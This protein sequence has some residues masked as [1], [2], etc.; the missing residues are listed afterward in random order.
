TPAP[1]PVTVTVSTALVSTGAVPADGWSEADS[2]LGCA[3]AG[4]AGLSAKGANAAPKIHDR[5]DTP[6]CDDDEAT[7][8]RRGAPLRIPRDEGLRIYVVRRGGP[9][10]Q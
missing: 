3:S 6:L 10:A 7:T 8:P 2:A 4:A 1:E 9:R 5:I